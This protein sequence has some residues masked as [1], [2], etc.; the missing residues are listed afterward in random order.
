MRSSR[1]VAP[2]RPAPSPAPRRAKPLATLLALLAIVV[3]GGTGATAAPIEAHR[4]S[5]TTAG[6]ATSD[7]VRTPT[8]SPDAVPAPDATSV[9]TTRY[10]E[11]SSQIGYGGSWGK[12][13]HSGFSAGAVR[14]AKTRGA[15]ATFTFVGRSV[16][17]YG[18]TGPTRGVAKVYLGGQYRKT[19]DLYASSFSPSRVLYTASYSTNATRTLK[20]VV[21]GT[22]GRP[23]VAIDS[24]VVGKNVTTST[25]PPPPPPIATTGSY[26]ADT[27]LKYLAT[28]SLARPSLL[29]AL[30]DPL[31]GTRTTRISNT[32]GVRH[33]YSRISAWNSDGS[34]ILLGFNYPGRML[35]GRT[36][37]DLGSFRQVSQAV[38]SN[39][40]PNKLYGAI[41]NAFYRQSATSGAITKLRA[42]TNYVSITI[43]DYEGG[44][45]D[46]D[47]YVALIGTTSGGS[48][49]LI[50]YDIAAN[51]LVADIA[52]PSGINNAQISRKGTYVVVVNNADGTARGQGVER[53]TR[54]LA[55]RINL[56]PYGRHG[57]N[58][59]DASGNEIYVSNNA[60]NVVAYNLATG[61]GRRLLSGTTAFEYGHVSGRNIK[62][63]GWIYLSVFNNSVTSGRPG[64][65][66][67]VAVKTDGSGIVEVFGFSHHTNTSNYAMQP[68][69]VPSPD[70]T[71]VLFAS[72]W[73]SSSVL[74]YVAGR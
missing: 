23:V 71:K 29:S 30:L 58:A 3:A 16:T 63:P 62:R 43:G 33:A 22:A 6:A 21:Q 59:L 54:N 46:D 68:H 10:Q 65:D 19:I 61:G 73:G 11:T 70:G 8:A 15:A 41:G 66:Q 67:I 50:T 48:R 28:P 24:L 34:K 27:T 2:S 52:V 17:W 49:H 7:S 37:R 25:P 57:D 51:S 56:T 31:L 64:H 12:A 36:Y 40:D 60:P 74:A 14:W 45:S 1:S 69:A 18:P 55:S 13:T 9:V 42:F 35:D 4:Q 38:W 5:P 72:E 44:I 47:R 26:P 32:D 20:I 53:Y 39:V